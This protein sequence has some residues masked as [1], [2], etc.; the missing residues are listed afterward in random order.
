MNY[1]WL[2]EARQQFAER[3]SNGRQAHACLIAGPRGLGK[4]GFALQM[5]ANLLCLEQGTVACGT[6]RSCTLLVSGAHP[7]F[8][9]LTF[10]INPK[11]DKMRTE[12]VVGQVRELNASMQL[13]HGLSPRK[14][15]VIH[16][17]EAMNKSA[18][19]AMLK[20]LEEPPVETLL[21]LVAH[22]SSR[23]L[24]TIRSRCQTVHVRLP[25]AEAA[26]N[27]LTAEHGCD[28][29]TASLALQ[30]AAGSPLVAL[31]MLA[32][33]QVD[34]YRMV[35]A[36]LG[37]VEN[38]ASNVGEVVAT[39]AELDPYDTWKWLS[40]M[41]AQQL[42][43]CFDLVGGSASASEWAPG[44]TVERSKAARVA[45]LQTLADQNRRL[46]SSPLRKDL[47]LRDWLIQWSSIIK[48]R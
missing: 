39:L 42:R 48:D 36:S 25:N 20:M 27:W 11:N 10:E 23:L 45:A 40:L 30:A 46:L 41:A 19:N 26:C 4:V 33:G 14:V 38:S 28:I 21:L 5:A 35:A 18:G 22:D 13:T 8:K 2:T 17:A 12:L 34:Q 29:E 31:H 37:Q 24:A 32:N 44:A 15:A 43:G 7:D 47:L 9:L 16:P 6:C 1:P 3:Q